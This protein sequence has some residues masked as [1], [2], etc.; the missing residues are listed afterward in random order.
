MAAVSDN[1]GVSVYRSVGANPDGSIRMESA[2]DA[3]VSGLRFA[4][5]T[6]L[7]TPTFFNTRVYV[8]GETRVLY[9]GMWATVA[10]H[11]ADDDRR[12][13]KDRARDSIGAT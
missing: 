8:D 1:G 13:N 3:G 4:A 10:D 12:A 5:D 6:E 2:P 11:A 9:R 7:P